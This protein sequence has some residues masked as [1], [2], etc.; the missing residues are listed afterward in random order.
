MRKKKSSRSFKAPDRKKTSVAARPRAREQVLGRK[1][2]EVFPESAHSP[3]AAKLEEAGE[4]Q[5]VL[6][7][8]VELGVQARKESFFI[9]LRPFS[10]GISVFCRPASAPK[11][12]PRP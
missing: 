12:A 8:R 11:Q 2:I 5:H 7:F 6:S 1:F 3:F 4:Q 10:A 9:Q